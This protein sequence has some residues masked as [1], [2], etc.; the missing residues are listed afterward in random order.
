MNLRQYMS[1]VHASG[2]HNTCSQYNDHLYREL[3]KCLTQSNYGK[4]VVHQF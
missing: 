3:H 4:T 2:L 1:E